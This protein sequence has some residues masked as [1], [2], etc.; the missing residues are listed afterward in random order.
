MDAD[1]AGGG[2]GSA[3]KPDD[4]GGSGRDAD[5]DRRAES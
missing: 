4:V 2:G 5:D 1:R 3:W